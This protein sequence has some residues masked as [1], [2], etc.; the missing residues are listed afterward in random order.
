MVVVR[1]FVGLLVIAYG[2]FNA[3]APLST[4]VY[5]A[6][7]QWPQGWASA[8]Q[9]L[10]FPTF[11]MGG[12]G[13]GKFQLLMQATNWLQIGMWL[14]ADFLYLIS[15]FWLMGSRPRN[16]APVFFVALV[17]DVATWLTFKRMAIYDMTVSPIGQQL[18]LTIYGGM[19][20]LGG[21]VWLTGLAK[22]RRPARQT[23]VLE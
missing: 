8:Q 5:K 3:I 21:L 11:T 19:A 4:A 16:A 18:D 22:R 17:L 23:L 12:A 15:A 1:W 2:A 20:I 6:K 7:G 9:V 13:S 14:L 10:S